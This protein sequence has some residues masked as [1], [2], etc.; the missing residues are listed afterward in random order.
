MT[1]KGKLAA[2]VYV[3]AILGLS[4]VSLHFLNLYL[5]VGLLN[6]PD[7]KT[8]MDVVNRNL[9]IFGFSFLA[10]SVLDAYLIFRF[11]RFIQRERRRKTKPE[12]HT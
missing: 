5:Y 12:S 4:Y 1:R 7:G 3:I 11:W 10:V 8:D 9:N 2:G 6:W